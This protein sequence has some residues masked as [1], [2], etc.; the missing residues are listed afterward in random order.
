MSSQTGFRS[1]SD[2]SGSNACLALV[3]INTAT[4]APSAASAP[5]APAGLAGLSVGFCASPGV[6]PASRRGRIYDHEY[7]A[8]SPFR[9]PSAAAQDAAAGRSG[10]R[11][12]SSTGNYAN[13]HTAGDR[14]G[15][16]E[17]D[18][19]DIGRAPDCELPA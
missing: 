8:V 17:P 18:S 3:V 12:S 10:A 19:S 2:R 4:Y 16:F 13:C 6:W 9:T 11:L 1:S 7:L 5:P 14:D 15:R